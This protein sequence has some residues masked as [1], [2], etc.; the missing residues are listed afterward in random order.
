M[1]SDAYHANC[2]AREILDHVTSRWA[3]LVLCALGGSPRRFFEIR[4]RVEGISD[5]MLSQT[6]RILVRDGLIERTVAPATP[7]Q[8]SYAQ[9][10]LGTAL[11]RPLRELLAVIRDRAHDI[12]SAQEHYDGTSQA[13]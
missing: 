4:E 8:V 5:K 11:S 7:P 3:V 12:T 1:D 2:P 6:L 10:P 9:T 13:V